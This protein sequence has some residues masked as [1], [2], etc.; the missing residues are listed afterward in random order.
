MRITDDQRIILEE[1]KCERLSSNYDNMRLIDNF[2]NRRNPSLVQTLQNEAMEE[3]IEGK[4]A[5]YIVKDK[6]DNILFF[7]S[8]KSGSLYDSHLDANVIKLFKTLNAY[9]QDSLS[10]PDLTDKQRMDL[11]I[12]QEK[13][14]SHKC[15]TR[16]DLDNLPKKKAELFADLEKELSKDVTHVGKTFSSIELVHFCANNNC[17]DVWASLGMPHSIG[18]IVFWN[19]IVEIVLKV[20]KLIGNQYLFLFAADLSDNDSLIGYYKDRLDFMRDEERATIKPIYD[21]SCEF[22][23][24]ETNDIEERRKMFFDNFNLEKEE[25]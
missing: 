16:Y 19:F 7:F 12:F 20:R 10:D 9:I 25:I 2:F 22:M 24:Q 11:N 18:V 17:D 15:V 14:R 6:Y 23:Y 3:D 13:I 4:I 1:L 8:L 5:Y 21:L